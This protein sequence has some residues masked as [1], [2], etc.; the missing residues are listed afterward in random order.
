MAGR[1][2]LGKF[3]DTAFERV[4]NRCHGEQGSRI[5][6]PERFWFGGHSEWGGHAVSE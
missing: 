3:H 2:S 5:D 6:G 1:A 4:R